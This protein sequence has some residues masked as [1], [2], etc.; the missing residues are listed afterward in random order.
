MSDLH[1]VLTVGCTDIITVPPV[2]LEK[3]FN[4]PITRSVV[5]QFARDAK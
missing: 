4:N 2:V 3:V 5:E 1:E